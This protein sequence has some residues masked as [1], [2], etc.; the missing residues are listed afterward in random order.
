MPVSPD[1]RELCQA[2]Y[3]PELVELAVSALGTY[4]GPDEAWVHQA[5]IRLSEGELHRLPRWLSEAEH[6]LESFRWYAEEPA[7]VSPESHRFAVEFI[8]GLIDKDL[9]KLPGPH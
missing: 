5:A 3:A 1:T 2:A 8:N 9:P 6:R 7:D 4:S